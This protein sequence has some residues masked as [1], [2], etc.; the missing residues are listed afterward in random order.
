MTTIPHNNQLLKHLFELLVS[1]REM[2][3]QQRVYERLE[4]LCLAELF[5]LGCHTVVQL[6]TTP[7]LTEQDWSARNRLFNAGRFNYEAAS[8]GLFT[9]SLR[10]VATDFGDITSDGRPLT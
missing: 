6:L 7:G 2:A 8:R 1:Q 5:T 10:H 9:E 3:A 4:L